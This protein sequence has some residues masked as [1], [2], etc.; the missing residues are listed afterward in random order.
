MK[1]ERTTHAFIRE[2]REEGHVQIEMPAL[3]LY[4]LRDS[5]EKS[6]KETEA[7]I[8][9]LRVEIRKGLLD[10]EEGEASLYGEEERLRILREIKAL[11]DI[12]VD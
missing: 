7:E 5:I 10:R 12:Y 6:I 9:K 8:R 1:E 4:V 3:Y 11:I 2:G